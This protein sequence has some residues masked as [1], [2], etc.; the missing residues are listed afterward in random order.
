[1]N[2]CVINGLSF[3]QQTIALDDLGREYRDRL[4]AALPGQSPVSFYLDCI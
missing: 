1:M 3:C 2:D 4:Q